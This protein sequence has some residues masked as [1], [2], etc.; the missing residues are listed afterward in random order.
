MEIAPDVFEGDEAPRADRWLEAVDVTAC[1]AGL[2]LCN[3][4]QV[5]IEALES[6][7]DTQVGDAPTE[8]LA[9]DLIRYAISPQYLTLREKMGIAIQ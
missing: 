9:H 4:I 3:D 7:R 5:A 8:T 1:R 2:L 6:T